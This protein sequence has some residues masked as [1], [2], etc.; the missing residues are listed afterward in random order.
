[1][2]RPFG[3]SDGDVHIELPLDIDEDTTEDQMAHVSTLLGN[4]TKTTSFILIARLRQLE[5]D[6]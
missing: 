6:I 1:M 4:L 5:S 2:G 3:I